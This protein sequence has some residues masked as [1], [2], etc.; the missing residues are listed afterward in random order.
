MPTK[1]TVLLT[2]LL[3]LLVTVSGCSALQGGGTD[4][5]AIAEQ[6]NQAMQD[7]DSYTFEMSMSMASDQSDQ[8]IDLGGSGAINV[9]EQRMR[10]EMDVMGQ[11]ITQYIIGQTMYINQQGTWIQ[12]DVPQDNIWE[13]QQ[14][15]QQQEI[16]EQATV[17]FEGN[18]TIDGTDVYELS[19]DIDEEQVMEIIS[20]QQGGALTE[21]LSLDD[22]TYTMYVA[23]DTKY[24]KRINADMSMSVQGQS[25]DADLE[26]TFQD[27]NGDI[28]I[29]LPPE[30]QNAQ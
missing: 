9:A 3:A 14:L 23:H 2:A 25:V 7:V 12:Q 15:A 16:L 11:S 19:V 26:M 20:Q 5:A 4:G 8:T 21:Q 10:M 24:L 13:Q 28:S 29:E 18:T 1:R 27:Y 17:N 22:V 6:S 30:A